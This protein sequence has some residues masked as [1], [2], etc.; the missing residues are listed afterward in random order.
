MGEGLDANTRRVNLLRQIV[1]L[2]DAIAKKQRELDNAR[3]A[4]ESA[5]RVE[6][7]RRRALKVV[8]DQLRAATN[9][10]HRQSAALYVN[11]VGQSRGILSLGSVAIRFSGWQG[12]FEIP[13]DTIY[14][15]Q[16]GTSKVPPRAGIPLLGRIAPGD[17]RECSALLL[18]VRDDEQSPSRTV[19]IADLPDAARWRDHIRDRQA[20]QRLAAAAR[21]ELLDRRRQA[22][23][24]LDD[25]SY[26]RA[27]CQAHFDAIEKELATLRAQLKSAERTRSKS[28]R[29]EMDAA[30]EE[31][32]RIEREALKRLDGSS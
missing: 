31:M 11:G 12:G 15:V 19:V 10:V 27:K 5:K 26:A 21:A 4:L 28:A 20:R 8:D 17:A 6:A 13:L 18:T 23:S 1:Q 32:I 9:E 7:E 24:L 22:E 3:A 16:V 14:D 29:V 2:K 25:A 30:L